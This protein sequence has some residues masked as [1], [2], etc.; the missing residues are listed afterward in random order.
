MKI[1]KKQIRLDEVTLMRT[2]LAILIVFMHSFTCY[3]GGWPQ[4]EGYKDIPAYMWIARTSF[5]F[6]LEAFVFISGYL[7]AFQR[8]TLRRV[9]GGILLIVNKLKRL[10]LPSVIFSSL[11]F[12]LFCSYKGIGNLIYSLLNGCGHMWFLPMLFWCFIG[13][14]LLEKIK[15]KDAWKLGF[16]VCLNL[17]WPIAL[18]LQLTPFANYMVYF[19]GG[20]YVYKHSDE[21]KK[22]IANKSIIWL[23]VLFA[24][25][26][27]FFRPLKESLTIGDQEERLFKMITFSSRKLCQFLYASIGTMAFYCTAVWYTQKKQLKQFTIK[28]ASCCFGIYL[29][30]QFILELLYYQTT[31]PSMLGPYWIP[32]CGFCVTII[33][34]YFISNLLLKTKV[35]RFLIG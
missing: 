12:V 4:P 13:E 29:F 25:V 28:L 11:Y 15:I 22:A 14:W 31:L 1:E 3:Q 17:F 24:V 35:G 10:I 32:W 5:A 19:Y 20:Y 16:L 2:I 26:F 8:F 34:S 27:V 30:Q 21:I 9:G 33:L 6:T 7:V 18:P 23:W